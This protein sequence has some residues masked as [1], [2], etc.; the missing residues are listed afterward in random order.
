M[1]MIRRRKKTAKQTGGEARLQQEDHSGKKSI[2]IDGDA[3]NQ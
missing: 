2:V 3:L 1:T